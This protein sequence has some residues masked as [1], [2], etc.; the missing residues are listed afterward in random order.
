MSRR[1]QRQS[2]PPQTPDFEITKSPEYRA[3]YASGV[4]GGL[5]PNDARMIFW[6]DR[7]EPELVPRGSPGQTRVGRVNR[8]LQVE[9]HVSPA[10]FKTIHQWMGRHIERHEKRFGEIQLGPEKTD[11]NPLVI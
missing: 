5:D 10:Q 9:I 4:F 3:V 2:A 1:N 7:L 6:L 11:E 8:E